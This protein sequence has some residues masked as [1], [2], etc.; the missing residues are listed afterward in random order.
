LPGIEWNVPACPDTGIKDA[1]FKPD[2]Q[3]RRIC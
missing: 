1:A 2:K 3:L